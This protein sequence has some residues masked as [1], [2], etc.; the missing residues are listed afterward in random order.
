MCVLFLNNSVFDRLPGAVNYCCSVD[1]FVCDDP[2]EVVTYPI[3][4]LN[5]LTPAG[6]SPHH[7]IT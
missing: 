5:S 3:E 2:T 6:I 4:Y 7:L 1:S